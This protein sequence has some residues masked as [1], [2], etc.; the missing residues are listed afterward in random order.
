MHFPFTASNTSISI[1][2]AGRM[3]SVPS[4]DKSFEALSAHLKLDDHD[5][6]VIEDLIEKPKKI[7]RLTAGAV[8]VIGS[9]V[10]HKGMPVNSSLAIKLVELLEAG[11]NATPWARFMDLVFLNPSE[12][13][14]ESLYD[15]LDKFN[16]PITEDGH[17]ITFKRVR[18]DYFDIHS[19]K[20]NNSPGNIVEMPRKHVNADNTVTC[21]R[22]LHVAATSY[23]GRFY[24]TSEGY[25]VVVC[26]V[27][28]ADVVAVP[29]DYSSA[30][31]RVCRY[32]VLGDAVEEMYQTIETLHVVKTESFKSA[33]VDLDAD[34]D[35]GTD[36]EQTDMAFQR[37][38][39][40]YTASAVLSGIKAHGQRGYSKMTGIPRTTLQD[41]V[42][43]IEACT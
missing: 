43:K 14:R 6:D 20:F 36:A 26:K 15:F 32:E 13:S 11:Y 29:K 1:F 37:N 38:G 30:K 39:V 33:P 40:T 17:F 41:W 10:Y 22:G 7:A 31:M 42:T 12:E 4:S 8:T 18:S 3:C 34:A 2:F 16:A 23:L 35:D 9:T 5:Y 21:S 28:P 24:A 27:S 19:G 25:H